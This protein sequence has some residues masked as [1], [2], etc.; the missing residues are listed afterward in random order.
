MEGLSKAMRTVQAFVMR[1]LSILALA[2]ALL[3]VAVPCVIAR[4]G[5]DDMPHLPVGQVQIGE[6]AIG[7]ATV[8]GDTLVLATGQQVRLVGLQA[9]K[10]PLGRPNFK[11]WPLA[12]QARE[13]LQGLADGQRLSLYYGGRQSDRYRR[14]LAHLVRADGVWIQG[15]MLRL[16]LARV[17]SFADNRALL[18]EMLML[19]AEARAARRGI[20]ALPYYRIRNPAE[21]V[22]DIDSFQLVEGRVVDVATI[23]RRTYI[24]FGADWRDDFTAVIE[25]NRR[26][27]FEDAGVFPDHLIGRRLRLR[28]WVKSHNGPSI[29]LSHPEQIEILSE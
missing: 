29:T 27:L 22:A 6:Q 28:G 16:G 15:E 1:R 5:G 20:W 2:C 17:Y 10:L 24:N 8:D 19:E 7:L 4:D 3:M 14:K 13:A 18:A 21:T 23:K 12:D 26:A 9:P 25:R 11:A